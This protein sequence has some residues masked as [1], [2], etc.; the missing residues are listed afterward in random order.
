MRL[1]LGG[2]GSVVGESQFVFPSDCIAWSRRGN[3]VDVRDGVDMDEREWVCAELVAE[4]KREGVER[5][6]GYKSSVA[7]CVSGC[8]VRMSIGGVGGG[9]FLGMTPEPV[10][11]C[12]L[13][14]WSTAAT[15]AACCSNMW[16]RME[17]L[18][19]A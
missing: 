1:R 11:W 10:P 16:T 17:K 12:T 14:W 4:R 8:P 19:A 2:A 7:R 5:A 3:A 9:R 15:S 13:A 18:W 6:A